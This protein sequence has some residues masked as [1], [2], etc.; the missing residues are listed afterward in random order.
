M[1]TIEMTYHVFGPL[2]KSN[3]AILL[4]YLSAKLVNNIGESDIKDLFR[5]V[6][7][8]PNNALAYDCYG[9]IRRHDNTLRPLTT[10]YVMDEIRAMGLGCVCSY[11]FDDVQRYMVSSPK[12]GVN[13]LFLEDDRNHFY[14]IDDDITATTFESASLGL[15]CLRHFCKLPLM[16]GDSQHGVMSQFKALDPAKAHL[17]DQ[18]L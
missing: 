3:A 14:L 10:D 5:G 7:K 13:L 17:F 1:A 11:V 16:L 15:L 6:Q 12:M 8:S 2:L 9:L 4:S 18:L